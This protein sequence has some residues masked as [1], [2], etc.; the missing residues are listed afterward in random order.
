ML[1]FRSTASWSAD[2]VEYIHI[3][4]NVSLLLKFY[5]QLN[6]CVFS[7]CVKLGAPKRAKIV[8]G[9]DRGIFRRDATSR[10]QSQTF[11]IWT[12]YLDISYLV[13]SHDMGYHDIS[14]YITRYNTGSHRSTRNI[15]IQGK[16]TTSVYSCVTP[17]CVIPYLSLSI[18]W[19]LLC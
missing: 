9:I 14:R 16:P 19:P 13:V 6:D 1:L 7:S 18:V 8:F 4:H 3:F 2:C 5:R 15:Q 10:Y 12:R 17:P 11:G